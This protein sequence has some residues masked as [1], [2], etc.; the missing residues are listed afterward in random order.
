MQPNLLPSKLLFHGEMER[1]FT[2]IDDIVLGVMALL[3]TPPKPQHSEITK[4]QA[5]FE[6]YNIGNNA[7][8]SLR[9]F[10]NAIESSIGKKA[11]EKMLPM[12]PGDVLSTFADI[13]PLVA[14]C[15]F[16]PNTPIEIGMEKF[17]NWYKQYIK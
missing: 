5:R 1:D 14:I 4:S 2:Y 12:Q 13:D 9:R 6:I 7:P 16:R 8:I 11:I 3:E 15:D 17:I 10:I